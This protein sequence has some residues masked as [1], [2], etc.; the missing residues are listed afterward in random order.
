[1]QQNRLSWYVKETIPVLQLHKKQKIQK[2][3]EYI[4]INKYATQAQDET[5]KQARSCESH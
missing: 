1:M 4:Y 5:S 2:K 3:E